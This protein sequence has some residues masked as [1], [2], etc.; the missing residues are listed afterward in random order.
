[1][2]IQYSRLVEIIENESI[3]LLQKEIIEICFMKN[4]VH[5]VSGIPLLDCD[6]Y[7]I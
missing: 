1:M 2:T 6:R 7:L 3:L 4:H 5:V